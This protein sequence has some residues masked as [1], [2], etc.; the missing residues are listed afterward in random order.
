MADYSYDELRKM[1]Q[2]ANAR[3]RRLKKFTGKDISWSGKQLQAKLDTGAMKAWSEKN[4]ITLNKKMS[5]NQLDRIHESVDKF[6]NEYQ[7]ST[8]SGA[9]NQAEK[10]KGNFQGK[11]D[12]SQEQAEKI[13]QAFEEDLYKWAF[14][15]IDPSDFWKMTRSVVKQNLSFDDF[16]D[17]FYSLSQLENKDD[18]TAVI[19]QIYEDIMNNKSEF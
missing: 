1:V 17:N 3:L 18:N 13:Y 4:Y 7:A 19:Y 5:K 6:L 11:L 8:I 16:K 2:K 14:D 15:F 9:K 10:L 12:I